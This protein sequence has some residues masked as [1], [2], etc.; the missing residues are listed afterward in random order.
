M[1]LPHLSPTHRTWLPRHDHTPPRPDH[2]P[3]VESPRVLSLASINRPFAGAKLSIIN[4]INNSFRKNFQKNFIPILYI[5]GL[6]HSR[7]NV[8]HHHNDP[9]PDPYRGGEPHNGAQFQKNVASKNNFFNFFYFFY[10]LCKVRIIKPVPR[11]LTKEYRVATWCS[12][13]CIYRNFLISLQKP[14]ELWVGKN[15]KR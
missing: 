12:F 2:L 6:K 1:Y 5:K 3:R 10:Y 7:P 11:V 8:S 14:K 4:L 15:W 13:S 9:D